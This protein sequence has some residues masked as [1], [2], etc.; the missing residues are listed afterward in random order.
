[1]LRSWLVISIENEKGS[2]TGLNVAQDN[3]LSIDN[4]LNFPLSIVV[5]KNVIAII[6]TIRERK[7][8]KLI[9]RD[10]GAVMKIVRRRRQV[11]GSR[12]F[13]SF[14]R[15]RGWEGLPPDRP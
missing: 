15:W 8:K 2:R 1:M 4:L 10:N 12:Y 11:G 6:G 7:V 13:F 3:S 9:S 5:P 14:L